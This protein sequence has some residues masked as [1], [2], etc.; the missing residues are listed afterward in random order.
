MGTT[1]ARSLCCRWIN[2]TISNTIRIHGIYIACMSMWR[3]ASTSIDVQQFKIAQQ[4]ANQ[5]DIN[6]MAKCASRS[7]AHHRHQYWKHGTRNVLPT[8]EDT[9]LYL[10]AFGCECKMHF[11]Y[12]SAKWMQHKMECSERSIPRMH[13][14]KLDFELCIMPVLTLKYLFWIH[15]T[16]ADGGWWNDADDSSAPAGYI[17]PS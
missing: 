4:M 11:I 14:E 7:V 17:R 2:D 1:R 15:F 12:S 13:N 9:E 8:P 10:L 3:A 16:L 6:T 5:R